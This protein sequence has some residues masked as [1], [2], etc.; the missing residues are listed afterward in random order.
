MSDFN[1]S[2]AEQW[3]TRATSYLL[4]ATDLFDL[5]PKR[6]R[7]FYAPTLHLGAQGIEM[8]LKAAL[9]YN[10]L[11]VEKAEA[12]GHRIKPM[13]QEPRCEPMRGKFYV[14][15]VLLAQ[16]YQG[17][18]KRL[19]SGDDPCQMVDRHL[20]Y[21]AILHG[22]RRQYPLRYPTEYAYK[23]PLSPLLIECAY[24]TA[25]DFLKN[26]VSCKYS[27]RPDRDSTRLD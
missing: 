13:W 4:A 18:P 21:I 14:N 22:K 25:D 17:G 6:G 27:D 16:E 3:A 10:G 9:I 12:Y 15:A 1:G 2:I 24:R 20:R 23:V 11:S 8:L 7:N 26:P 19:R 5:I